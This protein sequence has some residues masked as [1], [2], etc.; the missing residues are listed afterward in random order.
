VQRDVV[1][2]R[3]RVGALAITEVEMPNS[4]SPFSTD[5]GPSPEAAERELSAIAGSDLRSSSTRFTDAVPRWKIFI[6]HPTAMMGQISRI[7]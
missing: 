1:E 6:T 7:M 5:S 3:R 4:I 2:H